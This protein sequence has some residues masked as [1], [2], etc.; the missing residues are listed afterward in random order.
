V[1]S[2]ISVYFNFFFLL[3]TIMATWHLLVDKNGL[4]LKLPLVE[5]MEDFVTF[6]SIIAVLTI[7]LIW[8]PIWKFI[9]DRILL[10]VAIQKVEM[11]PSH[12]DNDEG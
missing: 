6:S 11:S 10:E 3:Y 1:I 9:R 5:R 12:A 8:E 7:G 2:F 4:Q